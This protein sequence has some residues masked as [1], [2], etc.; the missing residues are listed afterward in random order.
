MYLKKISIAGKFLLLLMTSGLYSCVTN[1][2]AMDGAE[3]EKLKGYHYNTA[4]KVVDQNEKNK[5][6]NF[7]A[8]RKAREKE[9]REIEEANT[10]ISKVKKNKKPSG[11]YK[12]YIH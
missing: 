9:V 5:E 4:K 6:K 7:K 1:F 3:K 10:K 11:E 12:F 2:Y 8:A